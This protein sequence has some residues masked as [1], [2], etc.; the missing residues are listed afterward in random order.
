MVELVILVKVSVNELTEAN[1][2]GVNG[3]IPTTATLVQLKVVTG[4]LKLGV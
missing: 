2:G 4:K 1:T 3:S